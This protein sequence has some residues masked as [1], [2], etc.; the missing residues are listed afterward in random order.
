MTSPVFSAALGRHASSDVAGQTYLLLL[1]HHIHLMYS[2]TFTPYRTCPNISTSLFYFL[3]MNKMSG[4]HKPWSDGVGCTMI[5][6]AYLT[7][8]FRSVYISILEL[9]FWYSSNLDDKG[10]RQSF[11]YL[12]TRCNLINICWKI[13]LF[14]DTQ[15]DRVSTISVYSRSSMART[16]LGPWKFI[17]DMG[18]SSHWEL[19][20]APDQG[21]N[22]DNLGFSFRSSLKL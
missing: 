15:S 12:Y 19:I 10:I 7:K 20:F 9:S 17:L 2:D 8:Y 18:S 16:S 3:F 14:P 22:G 21:A 6:Q 5:A 13:T 11:N 1:C 4:R